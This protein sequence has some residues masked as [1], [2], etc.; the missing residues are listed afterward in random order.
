MKVEIEEYYVKVYVGKKTDEII[1][2]LHLETL[3]LGAPFKNNIELKNTFLIEIFYS[4]SI[5]CIDIKILVIK[6]KRRKKDEFFIT[7]L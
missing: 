6:H 2:A 4:Y 5:M 3:F 7:N 1:K